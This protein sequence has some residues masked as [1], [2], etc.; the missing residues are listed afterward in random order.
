MPTTLTPPDVR[1]LTDDGLPRSEFP[2]SLKAD[3][4]VYFAPEA[5]AAIWKHASEKRSVEVCG[6]LVGRCERDEDGPFVAVTHTIRCDEATSKF[7]EVTFTHE[8]WAKINAEMDSQHADRRI[9]GWYH[10]HPDFGIF[11]SDRDTFIHQ[12]FF[13]NPGQVAHVVDPVRRVEGVFTWQGGRPVPCSHFWVGDRIQ[14]DGSGDRAEPTRGQARAV[15]AEGMG[16]GESHRR[17]EPEE[18]LGSILRAALPLL[19]AFLLGYFL[20]GTL[21]GWRSGSER[22]Q[23]FADMLT[24]TNYWKILKPGLTENLEAIDRRLDSAAARLQDLASA[25]VKLAGDDADAARKEW[26]QALSSLGEA[27]ELARETRST[28]GLTPDEAAALDDIL[29]RQME[30]AAAAERERE[31]EREAASQAGDRQPQGRDAE[32][33][34]ATK[35]RQ[36]RSSDPARRDSGRQQQPAAADAKTGSGDRKSSDRPASPE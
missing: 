25:H 11:L 30:R 23:M 32:A 17:P 4:R 33:P 20:S 9:V 36:P 10:T 8:S 34:S 18:S 26:T 31:R 3:F 1:Q 15:V 2:A 12:N 16:T 7:A 22:Q 27:R 28:Y 24:R 5:H 19:L 21:T 13:S 35:H 29:A 14:L 6:V